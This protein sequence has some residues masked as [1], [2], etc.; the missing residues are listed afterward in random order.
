MADKSVKMGAY[1]YTE[2]ELDKMFDEARA[3][4][5]EADRSAIRARNAWY[6]PETDRLVMLL[7]TGVEV[8]IPRQKLQRLKGA[9]PALVAEV[10]LEMGGRYLHWEKLDADFTVGGL[11]AGIFGSK[12]WMS[13]L[14]RAG[15]RSTSK[16]KR[17]ASRANGQLGGRPRGAKKRAA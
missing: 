14:G 16:A 4:G 10:E 6:D 9:P 12:V 2:R 15:G 5:R 8:A 3:R 11:V 1:S 7:T 13:E 17:A